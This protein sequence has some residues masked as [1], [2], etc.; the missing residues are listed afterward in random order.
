MSLRCLATL[1]ARIFGTLL[2]MTFVL[3]GSK[4]CFFINAWG[5]HVP[6]ARASCLAGIRMCPAR[7][8]R[9]P[10]PHFDSCPIGAFLP[11]PPALLGA[12][13]FQPNFRIA[14]ISNCSGSSGVALPVPPIHLLVMM[15]R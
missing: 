8:C 15:S 7:R 9:L 14:S 1:H 11:V 5:H 10:W 13:I 12:V 2:F 3:S 6:A 4:D